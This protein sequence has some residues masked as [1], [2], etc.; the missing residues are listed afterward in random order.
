MGASNF[1]DTV[2]GIDDLAKAYNEARDS[3]TYE[4]GYDPYNGTISTTNG[5]RLSP[6]NKAAPTREDLID[7]RAVD[8]RTDQLSKWEHCE[9]IRI[10]RVVPART[11]E[12][13]RTELVV[14]VPSDASGKEL[15]SE[16]T[17]AV[18]K[19]L[20]SAARN[21]ES[22]RIS[23]YGQES[24]TVKLIKGEDYRA[25]LIS[26][27][28]PVSKPKVSTKATKGKVKT[29]YFIISID[30]N[31]LPS[32]DEGYETQAQARAALPVTASYGS[33][34]HSWEIISISRR[35]NGDPLVTHEVDLRGSN[36]N[37]L[38]KVATVVERIVSQAKATGEYGW[39]FYG[40]AAE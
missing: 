11:E 38:Y 26:T 34:I 40:I 7:W 12:I 19:A 13:G 27:I 22:L 28:Q 18:S 17:K 25:A 36:K 9:A 3:A 30:S 10:E 14:S 23:K 35:E 4:Y 29:R 1:T 20:K 16:V 32:W 15:G 21:G 8:K 37:T 6:L 5:V 24:S 33:L 39:L 2:Y 31:R